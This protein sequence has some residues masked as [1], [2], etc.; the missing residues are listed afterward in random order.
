MMRSFIP[1]AFMDCKHRI[2]ALT[3]ACAYPCA[4]AA[5][6]TGSRPR[7]LMAADGA[8]PRIWIGHAIPKDTLRGNVREIP[9]RADR[10]KITTLY[11]RSGHPVGVSLSTG[12]KLKRDQAWAKAK[13]HLWE[14]KYSLDQQ[15][16]FNPTAT[17]KNPRLLDVRWQYD[18]TAP[19]AYGKRPNVVVLSGYTYGMEVTEEGFWSSQ[20]AALPG[21]A[22]A[23]FLGQS[24]EW[25]SVKEANP[26]APTLLMRKLVTPSG[27]LLGDQHGIAFANELNR[28]GKYPEVWRS[29]HSVEPVYKYS[30]ISSTAGIRLSGR[31]GT[32]S[33]E[34]T[35]DTS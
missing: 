34:F 14:T 25:Q 30:L 28:E 27:T 26:N 4:A 12:S 35:A 3:P 10:I 7:I 20:R 5:T 2:L 33:A 15:P 22:I 23:E 29:R 8:E 21:E 13:V 18:V 11:D 6:T 24:P 9:V 19:W 16:I 17:E 32:K 1:N 31:G